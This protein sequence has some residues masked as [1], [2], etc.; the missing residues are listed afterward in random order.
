MSIVPIQNVYAVANFKETQ[1]RRM[2]VGQSASVRVDALGDQLID[3]RVESF[4]PGTGA[5]F[6]LLP[7]ENLKVRFFVPETEFA[8][9]KAGDRVRV[10]VTGHAGTLEGRISFLS[11]QPE[12]TPPVLYNRDNRAKLVFMVEAVFA[13]DA[14]RDLHPGQPADVTPAP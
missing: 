12:Y 7:P 11:P 5:Q 6:A 8:A 13:G 4:S 9:L 2:R 3:A 10:A 14:A 1:I